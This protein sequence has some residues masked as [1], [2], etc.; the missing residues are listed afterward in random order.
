MQNR[1]GYGGNTFIFLFF[2]IIFIL[3]FNLAA[4]AH[5]SLKIESSF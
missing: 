5:A 3:S 4:S 1:N 2:L